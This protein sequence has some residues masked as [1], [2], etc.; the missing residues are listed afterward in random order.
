MSNR[1]P[2]ICASLRRFAVQSRGCDRF[3]GLYT[4]QSKPIS[5]KSAQFPREAWID[6]GRSGLPVAFWQKVGQIDFNHNILRVNYK[7]KKVEQFISGRIVDFF[8]YMIFKK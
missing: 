1:L 2:Y 8:L 7:N 4:E 3:C 6:T 5:G